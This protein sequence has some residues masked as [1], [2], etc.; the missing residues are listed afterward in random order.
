MHEQEWAQT[1]DTP[2]P[3]LDVQTHSHIWHPHLVG[4]NGQVWNIT[5]Q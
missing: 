2:S 1:T 5:M 3:F 4:V